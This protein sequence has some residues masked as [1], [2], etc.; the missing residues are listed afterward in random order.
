ME[1]AAAMTGLDGRADAS[2]K[3]D[4]PLAREPVMGLELVV[5]RRPVEVLHD[6][7]G[8]LGVAR[9]EV[10]DLDDVRVADARRGLGFAQEAGAGRFGVLLGQDDL[11]CDGV[12]E[13]DPVRDV[14]A[15]HAAGSDLADEAVLAV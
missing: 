15:S 12:A 6:D 5:E 2:K 7:V 10:E 9:T 13:R 3:R 1:D 4:S 14:D 11:D 8:P